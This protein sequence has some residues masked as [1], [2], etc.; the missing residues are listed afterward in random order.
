MIAGDDVTLT[1]H[2]CT[3]E[4]R[5]LESSTRVQDITFAILVFF[6]CSSHCTRC[7]VVLQAGID[8]AKL[9]AMLDVITGSRHRGRII[10]VSGSTWAKLHDPSSS[11]C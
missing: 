6:L 1:G 3:N 9:D 7:S 4:K 2:R 5:E 10:G 8:L 11:S